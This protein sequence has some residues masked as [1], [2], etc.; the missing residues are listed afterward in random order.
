MEFW[1]DCTLRNRN[2][3]PNGD[4]YE[5]HIMSRHFS[6][7]ESF[8]CR[9][10]EF[11]PEPEVLYGDEAAQRLLEL[12]ADLDFADE[13]NPENAKYCWTMTRD[14]FMENYVYDLSSRPCELFIVA[15]AT[16]MV[17][18]LR[19]NINPITLD[20]RKIGIAN[21]CNFGNTLV[22][23]GMGLFYDIRPWAGRSGSSQADT[24]LIFDWPD[25][26][27]CWDPDACVW[28]DWVG[29]EGAIE[30]FSLTDLFTAPDADDIVSVRVRIT[31]NTPDPEGHAAG[32]W[33]RS[34]N[35]LDQL[36]DPLAPL[37]RGGSASR[38]G[39]SVDCNL[40][41]NLQVEFV[42]R[43]DRFDT[44]P[45]VCS[46]GKP[47]K[48]NFEGNCDGRNT[49][50]IYQRDENGESKVFIVAYLDYGDS[51]VDPRTIPEELFVD[52]RSYEESK[53]SGW[54]GLTKVKLIQYDQIPPSQ[55]EFTWEDLEYLFGVFDW[56]V[57]GEPPN[58][59]CVK[60]YKN[61][62]L[63]GCQIW[64]GPMI[65]C[66]SCEYNQG[67]IDPDHGYLYMSSRDDLLDNSAKKDYSMSVAFTNEI[68]LMVSYGPIRGYGSIPVFPDKWFGWDDYI[69]SGGF[70]AIKMVE[71]Y[72]YDEN[73]Q[74]KPIV[75]DV[76]GKKAPVQSESDVMLLI[77]HG[78][79]LWNDPPCS[80]KECTSACSPAPISRGYAYPGHCKKQ[81]GSCCIDDQPYGLSDMFVFDGYPSDFGYNSKFNW[82]L[83]CDFSQGFCIKNDFQNNGVKEKFWKRGYSNDLKWIV[84]LSCSALNYYGS[85][86]P[87]KVYT[88]VWG[89]MTSY[90]RPRERLC[91][92][93]DPTT[94]GVFFSSACGFK[95]TILMKIIS[96]SSL[97]NDYGNKLN[98]LAP[99]YG[100]HD[101]QCY[102]EERLW[103][104][105]INANKTYDPSVAA[106]MESCAKLSK[107]GK[108]RTCGI[109]GACAIAKDDYYNIFYSW[110][111]V[112]YQYT[113]MSIW[114]GATKWIHSRGDYRIV[115][116]YMNEDPE[117]SLNYDK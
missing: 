86:K 79:Y 52:V 69:Q 98:F 93:L 20:V 105:N 39:Q 89:L 104:P 12:T 96:S 50:F 97:I 54:G 43:N 24:E 36:C 60:D 61:K 59:Q 101:E 57:V 38:A 77:S 5:T 68:P 114:S 19:G 115:K 70:E 18:S 108:W 62:N 41:S 1:A 7:S 75:C 29:E 64:M 13:S 112:Q 76:S 95:A 37:E 10:P 40:L 3:Q 32:N 78:A 56:V 35:V 34:G 72:R 49:S 58:H 23:A 48:V 88:D 53:P 106:F 83:P 84:L 63:C 110:H 111:L 26:G 103:E 102:K 47:K 28:H 8:D 90:I 87:F 17:T 81:T 74:K 30:V 6:F 11:D 94:D 116:L 45:N 73:N 100:N 113:E 55:R 25:P 91:N 85:N 33:R 92:L 21:S 82:G 9:L 117:H 15:G 31:D 67:T 42:A 2:G 16:D 44:D 51:T 107:V 22:D 109:N 65:V 99:K 80:T 71:I 4:P 27:Y 14:F 66:D 46:R